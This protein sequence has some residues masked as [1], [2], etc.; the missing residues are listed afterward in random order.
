MNPHIHIGD[1]EGRADASSQQATRRIVLGPV[2]VAFALL[3]LTIAL[4]I[5]AV[6]LI[7]WSG[8]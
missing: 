2:G 1:D 3:L 8:Q 4:S 5:G 7:S 6:A